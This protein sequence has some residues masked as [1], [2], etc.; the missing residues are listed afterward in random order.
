MKLRVMIVVTHLMGVGHLNRALTLARAFA[1]NGHTARL[2]SG[3]LPVPHLAQDDMIQL[4]P[5]RSDGEDF[6][7]LF[8]AQ[9]VLATPELMQARAD[10]LCAAVQDM[11][12][13]ILI[14]E[15]FPFGRRILRD[16]FTALLDAAHGMV[17]RPIVL[18]SLRD[19]PEPPSKPR[20]LAYAE[21]V[22]RRYY[23][24]ILVHSD[25]ALTRLADSWPLAPELRALEIYTGY[26]SAPLPPARTR[27]GAGEILVSAG[28]G[29]LGDAVFRTALATAR[30]GERWR[31]R[32][33]GHNAEARIEAL[34][35][36]APTNVTVEPVGPAF[37]D[38]LQNAR[39]SVSMFGYNTAMDLL[40]TGIPA[41][42][43][44][45]STSGQQEQTL[46]ARS[47]GRLAGLEV[48]AHDDL[49][50]GRLRTA[51]D[52][53]LREGPR[54]ATGIDLDGASGTV[55]ACERLMAG[56]V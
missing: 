16:E 39:A 26:V 19:V 25:P 20:K 29:I 30:P 14:T 53:V 7:R 22:V 8:D 44:P 13:D 3:G 49:T 46:R 33:G 1:E 34:R 23:D 27:E 51:L 32:I 54:D 42:V 2:V 48:V 12:P 41:V 56:R 38:L 47:L 9:D 4:P 36:Q 5:V 28:G 10:T 40:R 55:R 18:S 21:E 52:K 35:S 15:L 45:W 43:V 11:V 37:R 17:R 31:L 24:G 50:P 6:S